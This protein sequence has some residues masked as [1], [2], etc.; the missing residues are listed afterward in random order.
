MGIEF[1]ILSYKLLIPLSY[2]IFNQIRKMGYYNDIS[3]ILKSFM[4]AIIYLFAGLVYLIVLCRSRNLKKSPS[5]ENTESSENQ[6]SIVDQLYL[7]NQNIKKQR[8]IKELITIFLLSLINTMPIIITT[9]LLNQDLNNAFPNSVGVLFVILLF[10]FFSK[11]FLGS[12]IYKHQIIS[13]FILTFCFLIIL[14]IDKNGSYTFYS[15]ICSLFYM[16]LINGSASL[17]DVLIKKYF[18][19]HSNSPYRLMFYIGLFSFILLTALDLFVYFCDNGNNDDLFGKEV[20]IGIIENEELLSLK[21]FLWFIFY[22]IIGFFWLGGIILTLY[23][24]TPCHFIISKAISE[25]ISRCI[26]WNR[27]SKEDKNN[28]SYLIFIIFIILYVIIVFSSLV[29]NEVII[30]N[31]CSMEKNT[32]KYISLRE[33]SEFESVLNSYELNLNKRDN[34]PSFSSFSEDE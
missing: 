5:S 10:V 33:K 26:D 4:S 15:I 6:N 16:I 3:P 12:R 25:F 2:P 31:F 14:V 28:G 32:S 8:K 27:K 18:K 19:I 21:F 30:I 1:G 24:F 11:I 7:Q 34:T 29:Y 22:I 17:Y 20:I 13:L 9:L 23:Y